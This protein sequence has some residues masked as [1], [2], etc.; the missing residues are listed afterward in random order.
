MN[1]SLKP[2]LV[3]W[4]VT[5]YVYVARVGPFQKTAS[6]AW[7][8]LQRLLPKIAEDNEIT[9]H[10]ALYK[11][12]ELEYRAGVSIGAKP[13][14][15]P[16]GVDYFKYKGGRYSQFVLTGPYSELPEASRRVFEAVERLRLT[17]R[18]A[19]YI[20]NYVTDPATTPEKKAITEILVP[21]A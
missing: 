7:E 15:L 17:V 10:L 4:P 14:K 8:D 12:A 20:E 19:Y 11:P 21:T 2:S 1:L 5:H 9:G 16:E 6:K 13:R 18:R 3:D